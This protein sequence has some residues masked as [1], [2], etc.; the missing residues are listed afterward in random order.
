MRIEQAKMKSYLEHKRINALN[1]AMNGK[2]QREL[3]KIINTWKGKSSVDFPEVIN[4]RHTKEKMLFRDSKKQQNH[5][6][7]ERI[8]EQVS[9]MTLT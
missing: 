5:K 9:Q 8:L 1:I 6:L 3:F 4:L 7:N 2:D